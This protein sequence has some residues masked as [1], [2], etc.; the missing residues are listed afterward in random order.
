MFMLKK[1]HD[2]VV[3]MHE[4][5]VETLTRQY[6]RMLDDEYRR[7]L[8]LCQAQLHRWARDGFYELFTTSPNALT[9][10]KLRGMFGEAEKMLSPERLTL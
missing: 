3:E 1:T 6:Q 7:A 8:G 10:A 2:R 5:R 4:E 9:G